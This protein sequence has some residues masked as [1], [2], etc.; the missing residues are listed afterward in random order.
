MITL[1]NP[2]PK[3]YWLNETTWCCTRHLPSVQLPARLDACYYL[4]CPSLRPDVGVVAP[5]L[6]PP[7]EPE[8]EFQSEPELLVVA[9]VPEPSPS[10]VEPEPVVL[11]PVEPSKKRKPKPKR[12][13]KPER[14]KLSDADLIAK[15]LRE[16]QAR[17][18][19]PPAP[20]ADPPN[21]T[22]KNGAHP[23]PAERK[24]GA[25]QMVLCSICGVPQWRR[26]KDVLGRKV[27][28]CPEHKNQKPV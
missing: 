5:A 9:L 19:L 25:T 14:Q 13:H 21:S 26:P 6:A 28:W 17:T 24:R 4:G 1:G 10:V 11:V 7:V 3:A 8:P 20:E 2:K 15:A 23:T 12:N 16:F 22:P 27:F 18:D